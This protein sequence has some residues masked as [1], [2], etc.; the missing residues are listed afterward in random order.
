[1]ACG[2]TGTDVP[3]WWERSVS[4]RDASSM[5]N[6]QTCAA[7]ANPAI[8][9]A[10][11]RVT[12][13]GC[14]GCAILRALRSLVNHGQRGAAIARLQ[15]KEQRARILDVALSTTFSGR[16]EGDRRWMIGPADEGQCLRE[17]SHRFAINGHFVHVILPFGV[18]GGHHY[19][20]TRGHRNHVP[21][22][23]AIDPSP[24][25]LCVCLRG[26]PRRSI[27]RA[28]SST[29]RSGFVCPR[30]ERDA[31]VLAGWRF[32]FHLSPRNWR[33]SPLPC[34]GAENDPRFVSHGRLPCSV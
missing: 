10:R 28:R 25:V 23:S 14:P 1:M 31:S 16:L 34:L 15:S 12:G 21:R 11:S 8:P 22:H 4:K 3:L 19:T 9:P 30:H 6:G 32:A 18:V 26:G 24:T 33:Q 2:A 20:W 13:S 29:D 17:L 27:C 5:V 7:P